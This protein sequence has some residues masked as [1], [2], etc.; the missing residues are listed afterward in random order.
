V[1]VQRR[2]RH[3]L[4]A[5]AQQEAE[6]EATQAKRDAE[7]AKREAAAAKRKEEEA[8]AELAQAKKEAAAAA[9]MAEAKKEAVVSVQVKAAKLGLLATLE[10]AGV[11]L[12]DATIAT[13]VAWCEVEE[14]ADIDDIVN[15]KLVDEFV[16]ALEL[17]TIP[18][19]K[20]LAALKPKSG[21]GNFSNGMNLP[22]AFRQYDTDGNGYLDE[23]EFVNVL[24]TQNGGQA[25]TA[26]LAKECY[27]Y[28]D[29]DGNGKLDYNE[30][31][32][33]MAQLQA[34]TPTDISDLQNSDSSLSSTSQLLARLTDLADEP[35]ALIGPITG[36]DQTPR[37]S[38]FEAAMATGVANMDS[39]AFVATE[40]G[41]ELAATDTH[42]L[43]GNE[44]GAFTL[45]TMATDLY[46]TMNRLLRQRNRAALKP[47]FPYLRLLLDARYKLPK[48]VGVVW[49]GVKGVDMRAQ[50]PKGQEV[51]WWAFSSTTKELS[52]L[53]N[54]MF[55]GTHGVRTIF[56][57]QVK[58]GVDVVRY[59]IF[60]GQ[61]SE[62]EVLLYPGTKLKVVDAMNMGGGL[63]M[64]HLE[65]ID[66]PVE[67]IK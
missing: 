65:E 66:V 15:F 5:E 13:A 55:L 44:T 21:M 51:Y 20:M 35:L 7:Q 6:Q 31:C 16:A 11:T 52:T 23:H 32:N 63:Y 64:I 42:G 60:Q 46:P 49:R 19:E 34:G 37:V 38:L 10:A 24:T 58:R 17:K 36:I 47:F 40:R 54:P 33:A 27:D 56:N 18:R 9:R 25:M 2:R 57:I 59:S 67:L 4:A 30:F 43:D 3:S 29:A 48:Y 45:Y 12:S 41:A 1:R 53:Q 22:T 8:K 14:V 28:F 61:E 39:N 50:Y 26:E 62:A